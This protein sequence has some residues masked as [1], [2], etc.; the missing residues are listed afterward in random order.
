M[1]VQ[2]KKRSF[3]VTKNNFSKSVRHSTYGTFSKIVVIGYAE[4]TTVKW[5]ENTVSPN[6]NMNTDG[7]QIGNQ[8]YW[9]L[10]N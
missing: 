9:T 4:H 1:S 5:Q 2:V 6:A 10:T 8:V 3:S 7:A